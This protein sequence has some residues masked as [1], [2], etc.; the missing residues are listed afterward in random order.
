MRDVDHVDADDRV[1]RCDRPT[2]R[3]ALKLMR[4]LLIM[5]AFDRKL[6]NRS[7]V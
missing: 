2:D 4:K 3:D 7:A 5:V 6:P 1:S